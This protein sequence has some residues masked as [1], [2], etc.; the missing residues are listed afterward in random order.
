[1]GLIQVPSVLD[2]IV[3]VE[4]EGKRTFV[5]LEDI[6]ASHCHD[7]FKGCH[8]LDMVSFRVTRDSDL[9]LEEDDSVDLMKEVEESLRKRKRGAAV[10]LEIFKTNNN[11]I[12]NFSRK[13]GCYGDGGL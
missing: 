2:R 8:I 6:I 11:R 3:E 7:L 4:P 9:D 12:K 13:S 5:F 10:R 1:M